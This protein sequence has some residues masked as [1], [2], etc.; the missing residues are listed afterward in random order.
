MAAPAIQK[1]DHNALFRLVRGAVRDAFK[2]HPEYLTDQGRSSAV[3]SVTKRVVGQIVGRATEAR[4]RG[5]LGACS[6]QPVYTDAPG[7]AGST[8]APA[9]PLLEGDGA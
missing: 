5:P 7:A 3:S 8:A 1:D 6:G 4:K 9:V 2:S